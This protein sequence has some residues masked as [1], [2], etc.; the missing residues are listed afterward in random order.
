MDKFQYMK[1]DGQ[2]K[3]GSVPAI[4]DISAWKKGQ[5]D[6]REEYT[7]KVFGVTESLDKIYEGFDEMIELADPD[8]FL[9]KKTLKNSSTLP[10]KNSSQSSTS[11]EMTV[12]S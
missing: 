8:P 10:Q 1:I 4:V 12:V 6:V 2:V 7:L 5:D 9:E 11:T 3:D